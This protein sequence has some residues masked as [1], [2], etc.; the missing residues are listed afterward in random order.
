MNNEY[1]RYVA[2]SVYINAIALQVPHDNCDGVSLFFFFP[3]KCH[4]V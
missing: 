2:E 1:F 4:N 3:L